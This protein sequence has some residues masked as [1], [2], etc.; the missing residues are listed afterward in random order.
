MNGIEVVSQDTVKTNSVPQKAESKPVAEDKNLAA[1]TQD[2]SGPSDETESEEQEA[3]GSEDELAAEGETESE[4]QA[5]ESE[6]EKLEAKPKKKS[7][8]Q[9]KIDKLTRRL[10]EQE[11]EMQRLMEDRSKGKDADTSSVQ[12][13]VD[14]KPDGE[15]TPD[16]YG[17][18]AEYVRALAR[19]EAKQE[20]RAEKEKEAKEALVSQQQKQ[21]ETYHGRV[22]KFAEKADDFWDVMEDVKHIPMNPVLNEEILEHELGPALI[23]EL[24]KDPEE[25]ARINSL[26]AK[27]AL[28]ELWKIE[29]KLLDKSANK[30]QPK[31][32]KAPAPITP[33]GKKASGSVKPLHELD[34]DEYM[35]VR[36]MQMAKAAKG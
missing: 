4:E 17:T 1:E 10:H 28:K 20:L 29:A 22:E 30:P 2:D 15:P 33:V 26:S 32:T 12:S 14:A 8:Y 19:F 34:P 3:T 7:G 11:R 6:A 31:T 25:F 27:A 13:K 18:H 16:Q 35:K 9:K 23:Y 24:S 5:E 36:R 21:I